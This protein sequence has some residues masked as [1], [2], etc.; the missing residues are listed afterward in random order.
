MS[1][2]WRFFLSRPHTFLLSSLRPARRHAS[3][4][5]TASCRNN[6]TGP[7]GY[8]SNSS[9][10]SHVKVNRQ[11]ATTKRH[12][13]VVLDDHKEGFGVHKLDLDN[14]DDHV[15]RRGQQHRGYRRHSHKPLSS[16]SSPW[17]W[18]DFESP[19]KVPF[20]DEY[21]TA[22]ATHASPPGAAEQHELFVS[23]RPP[24]KTGGVLGG[25]FYF[26]TASRKWR[27][28]GKWHL[29]V[30]GR[31]H[32]DGHLDA[33]VG[34]HAVNLDGN[35]CGPRVTADGHLCA[36]NVRSTPTKWKVGKEKLFSLDE[37]DAAGWRQVDAKLVKIGI[38]DEGGIYS[39][40]SS[41]SGSHGQSLSQLL[42]SAPQAPRSQR[43]Q[44]SSDPTFAGGY[45]QPAPPLTGRE[46]LVQIQAP[47]QEDDGSQGRRRRGAAARASPVL[48]S[49]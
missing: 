12:L 6:L 42:H 18:S 43:R 13:Y 47:A 34:L 21:I 9:G 14:D 23:I 39:S 28:R 41:G 25:T 3:Q 30:V 40:H 4:L 45:I 8:A 27:R 49:R 33:W 32:Y 15:R 22:H 46:F 38:E 7:R 16:K 37:D 35:M 36:G 11:D 24:N 10:D 5:T 29:P 20:L 17:S 44:Q 48:F 26:S 31:A 2:A 1:R 19:P